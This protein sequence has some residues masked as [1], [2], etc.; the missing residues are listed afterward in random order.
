VV[1]DQA[2][3]TGDIVAGIEVVTTGVA[4]LFG[5]EFGVGK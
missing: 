4:E 2:A 3:L 5:T 1:D